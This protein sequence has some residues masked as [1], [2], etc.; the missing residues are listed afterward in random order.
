MTITE[1]CGLEDPLSKSIE[2]F[3]RIRESIKTKV[4]ELI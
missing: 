1:Y 2:K 3:G 4:E